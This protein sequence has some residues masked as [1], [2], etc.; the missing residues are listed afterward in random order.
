MMPTWGIQSCQAVWYFTG[1]APAVG[2][3]YLAL[4]GLPP[5]STQTTPG[6]SLAMGQAAGSAFRLQQLSGRVDFFQQ[7]MTSPGQAGLPLFRDFVT[8]MGSFGAKLPKA[9]LVD[10]ARVA[11]VVAMA[12]PTATAKDALDLILSKVGFDLPFGDAT[13]FIF[14]INRRKPFASIATIEMNRVLKWSAEALQVVQLNFSG[15]GATVHFQNVASFVVD[16]SSA[17]GDGKS[18]SQLEQASMFQE[19]FDE[20]DRLCNANSLGSLS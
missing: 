3:L 6:I 14:Q 8:T 10:V 4:V 20:A 13:D 18:F 1:Q 19:L 5:A 16:V 9:A 2:D 12:Q 11:L 17:L 7:P 15:G